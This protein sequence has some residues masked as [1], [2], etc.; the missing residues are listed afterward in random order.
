MEEVVRLTPILFKV[1]TETKITVEQIHLMGLRSLLATLK[2]ALL[3][4]IMGKPFYEN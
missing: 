2:C 3:T 4:L 1:V